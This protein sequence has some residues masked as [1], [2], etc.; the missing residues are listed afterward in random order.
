MIDYI[1]TLPLRERVIAKKIISNLETGDG[2][3]RSF[4]IAAKGI[5]NKY[6]KITGRM[7][8][9]L[10]AHNIIEYRVQRVATPTRFGLV[11]RPIDL[12]E[13]RYI[14]HY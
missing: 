4:F 2:K 6:I 5:N 7:L 14:P 1:E 9:E 3:W 12:P 8:G 10:R 13:Y 11:Q